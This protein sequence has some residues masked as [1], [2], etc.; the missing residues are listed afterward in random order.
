MKLKLRKL[1]AIIFTLIMCLSV[2]VPVSAAQ[3]YESIDEIEKKVTDFIIDFYEY[4]DVGCSKNNYSL[5]M[6]GDVSSYLEGKA[7]VQQY[8]TELYETYKDNYNVETILLSSEIKNNNIFFTF[9]IITTYNYIDVDF[10]T[11][12]SE[13]LRICYDCLENKIVEFC[14]PQNYYDMAIAEKENISDNL[15]KSNFYINNG[16]SEFNEAIIEDINNVYKTESSIKST[17]SNDATMPLAVSTINYTSVV[18]YARNNYNKSTPARGNSAVPYYDFS[19]ISGNYDCTNFVSHALLAGGAKVY[20][21]GNSGISSSGWYFRSIS[22]R[23]SSWSGVPNLYNYLTTNKKANTAAGTGHTYTQNGA[24]WGTGDV[25]QFAKSGS[26]TYS[27]STI[28]TQKKKSSDNTRSYAYVT[29]RTSKTSYNNNTAAAD[30]FP[31][32]SKRTIMVF[33]N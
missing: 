30:M 28:I 12:N 7:K 2:N 26:S 32:G 1:M 13:E 23:S 17:E 20:D 27:H 24:Y 4:K 33:N 18:N 3:S 22:N 5:K 15:M 16:V 25:L 14:T 11:T 10:E 6:S 19:T 8:V 29:G 9:Q 31:N 21:P